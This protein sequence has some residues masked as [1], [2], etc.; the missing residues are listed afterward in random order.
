MIYRFFLLI[1]GINICS[2]SIMFDLAYLN[3]LTWG[4]SFFDYLK[5]IFTR[6]ECVMFFIGVLLIYISIRKILSKLV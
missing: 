6:L 5:F 1:V 4:F 3:L 2:I